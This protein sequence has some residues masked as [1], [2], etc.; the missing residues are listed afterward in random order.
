M[1]QDWLSQDTEQHL[2]RDLIAGFDGA[3]GNGGTL[4]DVYS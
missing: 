3:I 2:T 4:M 1:Q